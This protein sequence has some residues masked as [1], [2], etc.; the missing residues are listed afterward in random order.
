MKLNSISIKSA[1]GQKSSKNAFSAL[2]ITSSKITVD[3]R[4]NRH[5]I[6]ITLTFRNKYSKGFKPV[7]EI[8]KKDGTDDP[9]QHGTLINLPS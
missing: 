9:F 5:F 4:F 2:D 7:F 3:N 8:H 6:K 1:L